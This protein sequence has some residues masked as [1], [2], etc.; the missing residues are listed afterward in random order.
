M[1]SAILIIE[2]NPKHVLSL[3]QLDQLDGSQHFLLALVNLARSQL[4]AGE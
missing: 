3:G 2:K 1:V 4:I